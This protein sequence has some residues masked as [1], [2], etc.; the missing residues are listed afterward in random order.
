MKFFTNGRGRSLL[1]LL[2]LLV[3]ILLAAVSLPGISSAAIGN[4]HVRVS[5]DQ[6][7]LSPRLPVQ[8]TVEAAFK[9]ANGPNRID[10]CALSLLEPV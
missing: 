2:H 3:I 9:R 7:R 8:E 6:K 1:I 5:P 4:A 10:R